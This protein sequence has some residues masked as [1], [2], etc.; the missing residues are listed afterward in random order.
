MTV[1]C[2]MANDQAD[3]IYQ[4]AAGSRAPGAP[5]KEQ[6]SIEPLALLCKYVQYLSYRTDLFFITCP[7]IVYQSLAAYER[8]TQIPSS[9]NIDSPD[10]SAIDQHPKMRTF[11]DRQSSGLKSLQEHPATDAIPLKYRG[12]TMDQRDMIVLGKEQVLRV[13]KASKITLVRNLTCRQRNF[14]FITMLGFASTVMA[15]WEVLLPYDSLCAFSKMTLSYDLTKRPAFS[16]WSWWM[17]E[18][19]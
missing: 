4:I 1:S 12:T 16:P 3:L 17:V 8:P 13:C 5:M 9:S 18:R 6:R 7:S 14:K 15:S 19:H 10:H 2:S 11:R